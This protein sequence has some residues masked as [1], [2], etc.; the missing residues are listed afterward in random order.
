MMA[1]PTWLIAFLDGRKL[2]PYYIENDKG[3]LKAR[4]LR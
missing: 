2:V 1:C 3:V 4:T